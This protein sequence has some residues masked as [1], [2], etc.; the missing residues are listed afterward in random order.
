M[1]EEFKVK[2]WNNAWRNLKQK[3]ENDNNNNNHLNIH[4]NYNNNN[5]FKHPKLQQI[6]KRKDSNEA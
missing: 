2:R 5:H 4:N 6:D 1:T 3:K